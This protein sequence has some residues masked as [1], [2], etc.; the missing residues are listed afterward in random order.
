MTNRAVYSI[1]LYIFCE[2]RDTAPSGSSGASSG[3]RDPIFGAQAGCDDS[4]SGLR[5]TRVS[6]TPVW[7]ILCRS[8]NSLTASLSIFDKLVR[9]RAS[10]Y[11]AVAGLAA[12]LHACCLGEDEFQAS[13]PLGR[14]IARSNFL[15]VHRTLAFDVRA[16]PIFRSQKFCEQDFCARRARRSRKIGPIPRPLSFCQSAIQTTRRPPPSLV[17]SALLQ[18]AGHQMSRHCHF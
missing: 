14:A 3:A 13:Q 6:M 18:S 1:L 7:L 8:V 12:I 2:A 10:G 17:F 15:P 4:L 16:L 5:E 9:P 11:R